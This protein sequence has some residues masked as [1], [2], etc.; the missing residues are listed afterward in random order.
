MG[1]GILAQVLWFIPLLAPFSDHFHR[2]PISLSHVWAIAVAGPHV[3]EV[4]ERWNEFLGGPSST[5]RLAALTKSAGRRD[6]LSPAS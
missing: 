1:A 4:G 3:P 2:P 6:F 5:V